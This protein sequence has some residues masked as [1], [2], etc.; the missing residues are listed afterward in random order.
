MTA[1]IIKNT[2]IF[3]NKIFNPL[4]TCKKHFEMMLLNLPLD[5]GKIQGKYTLMWYEFFYV[6]MAIV[7]VVYSQKLTTNVNQFQQIETILCKKAV[8]TC[9]AG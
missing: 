6:T 5:D 2:L 3:L 8:K 1:C 9:T 7:M 4:N